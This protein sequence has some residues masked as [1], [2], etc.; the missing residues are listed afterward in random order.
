M[1]K[2]KL[3]QNEWKWKKIYLI[4]IN[5]NQC[6]SII[7][8][9][10]NNNGDN[11]QNKIKNIYGNDEERNK[12]KFST[13]YS[14]SPQMSIYALK[15]MLKW[16]WTKKNRET[17]WEK[18]QREKNLLEMYQTSMSRSINLSDK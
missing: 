13:S 3:S 8:I 15:L 9:H 2:S 10:R 4:F 17:E 12:K 7:N 1:I 5:I 6:A 11:K 18:S 14:I 16:I